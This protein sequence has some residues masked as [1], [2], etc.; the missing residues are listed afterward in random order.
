M[1]KNKNKETT[2]WEGVSSWYNKAVGDTGHYY[3]QQ[4]ILPKIVEMLSLE[5]DSTASLLDLACG[6]GILSRYLTKSFEYVGID[7]SPSLIEAAKEKNTHPG[8]K[9]L[10]SDITKPLPLQKKDFDFC[11][12]ILAL[13]NLEHPLQAFKN[14]AKHLAKNGKILLVMN[15]PC[16]RIPKKSS[17]GTDDREDIQYRRI[18]A[19]YSSMKIPI[20]SNPSLG[21][22]SANTFSFHHPLSAWTLWLKE[23][24]FAIEW[25][26]EWCSDKVST[27]R[28]AMREDVSREEFPL[29][30]AIKACRI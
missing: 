27:G 13:Q 16:F 28:H 3:H 1:Q 9:F 5:E 30:L 17:W 29:F 20:Q 23:A 11:T 26:E 12:I 8:H 18:D 6:Q 19:Y 4:I 22:N 15:H 14:I 25:L 2:S 10:V 24:G 21:E 7:I